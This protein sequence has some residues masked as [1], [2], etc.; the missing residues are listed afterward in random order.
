MSLSKS[1]KMMKKMLEQV[2]EYDIASSKYDNYI[3]LA[4]KLMSEK[5]ISVLQSSIELDYIFGYDN[6]LDN[7]FPTE[8]LYIDNAFECM[9][10]GFYTNKNKFQEKHLFTELNSRMKSNKIIFVYLDMCDYVI[11]KNNKDN[12]DSVS[13][14][15]ALI[16]Y[17]GK[18]NTYNVYHFNSHGETGTYV[19]QYSKYISRKRSKH[20]KLNT[21]LDRY[22]ITRFVKSY[23]K[24]ISEYVENYKLLNY[25][26]TKE[27]NYVGTNLQISDEYGVCY[28][29]PFILFYELNKFYEN[30][31]IIYNS[32]KKSLILP[33]YKQLI[34]A[35]KFDIILYLILNKYDNDLGNI[36]FNYSK[37]Q[38][39]RFVNKLKIEE[40]NV[41]IRD[42]NLYEKIEAILSEKEGCSN[43]I[44][45]LHK[46]FIKTMLKKEIKTHV[47]RILDI[48]NRIKKNKK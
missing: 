31:N 15:T 46:F 4:S 6:D 34:K 14:S 7:K 1:N 40:T 27:Y 45:K 43:Y 3:H 2:K 33:S 8:E 36:L 9:Y 30:K 38:K 29:F 28:I 19:K 18:K 11:E 35:N 26:G 48:K 47:T 42:Y 41:S 37:P 32:K 22:L 24:H 23:N 25:K 10:C 5:H 13:H 21:G 39:I 12:N 17:P 16:F 44:M 20:I